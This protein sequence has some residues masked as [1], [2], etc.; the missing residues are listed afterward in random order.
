MLEFV[1][2]SAAYRGCARVQLGKWTEYSPCTSPCGTGTQSRTRPVVRPAQ[3]GGITCPPTIENRECHTQVSATYSLSSAY[4]LLTHATVHV[5]PCPLPCIPTAW[6]PWSPC[7]KTCGVGQQTRSRRI[8]RPA[9]Y[10][11][12]SC[13]TLKETRSCNTHTCPVDCQV[14]NW[15]KYSVCTQTCG[16]GTQSRT[17]PI[18]VAPRMGGAECPTV[19]EDRKC[20]TDA[21]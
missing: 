5:Q 8:H 13:G 17:R 1:L 18:I 3:Y 6:D 11:G 2:V 16:S 12:T 4:W 7:T 19:F 21:W 15:T 20:N 14:G 10:N 9:Q